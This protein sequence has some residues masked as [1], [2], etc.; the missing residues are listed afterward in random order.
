MKHIHVNRKDHLKVLLSAAGF[1][2]YAVSGMSAPYALAQG[3]PSIYDFKVETIDGKKQS[4]EDYKGKL[5]LVV[6]TASLCGY[7]PQYKTLEE[8]YQKYKDAGFEILAF[9]ANNFRSQ[10]PGTNEE[11]KNF[12]TLQY[13]TTFPL[14]SKISV[15]GDDIHPLYQYLTSQSGFEGPISWN[16]NKFLISPDGHVLARFDSKTD[17]M[18]AEI[19]SAVE[20]NLPNG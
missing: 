16:F 10:E 11:I 13:K 19:I 5:L 18:S 1:F 7:T 12:C 15:K 8:L 14:F 17:P 20:K 3:Q 2:F 4:L 9:P 6:N